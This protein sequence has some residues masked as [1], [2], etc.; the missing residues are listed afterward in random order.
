MSTQAID[1]STY[2]YSYQQASQARE[3]AAAALA[4][5]TGSSSSSSSPNTLISQVR[6]RIESL[7]ADVPRSNGSKLTF[8]DVFD[9]R[10]SQKEAWN[11][12]FE[13]DMTELGVDTATPISLS[14][15]S[16]TGLVTANSSHPDKKV[17]D[18][19]FVDNPEMAEQF[20]DNV[21]LNKLTSYASSTLTTSELRQSLTA[22]SMSIWYEASSGTS[23]SSLLSGGGLVYSGGSSS[24]AGLNI[25]V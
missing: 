1:Y 10:D 25:L 14:V 6:E 2:S 20:A 24:Y 19:Y 3:E 8:Q 13:T 11:E 4:V 21:Q 23:S 15:D 7:L 12:Q 5:Q 22:Q 18:Q 17:I 16:S 9:Y